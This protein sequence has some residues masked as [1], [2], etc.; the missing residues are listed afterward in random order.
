[1]QTQQN[2]HTLDI[3]CG[4]SLQEVL[5]GVQ[6]Q[7]SGLSA[8]VQSLT[9]TAKDLRIQYGQSQNAFAIEEES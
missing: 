2:Q 5:Q 8:Q 9:A 6:E 3:V 4:F 7:R 1:M